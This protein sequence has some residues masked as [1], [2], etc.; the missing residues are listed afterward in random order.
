MNVRFN[1]KDKSNEKTLI[2]LKIRYLRSEKSP[3]VLSTSQTIDPRFWD[4]DKMRAKSSITEKRKSLKFPQHIWLNALLDKFELITLDCL[5]QKLVDDGTLPAYAE[6]REYIRN[7]FATSKNKIT[8]LEYYNQRIKAKEADNT[9]FSRNTI[10]QYTTTYNKIL[11]FEKDTGK[12][13]TWTRMSFSL[14]KDFQQYLYDQGFAQNSIASYWAKLKVILTEAHD[15]ELYPINAHMDRKNKKSLSIGY[16]KADEV[17]LTSSELM[18]LYNHKLNRKSQEIDRDLFLL[19]AFTGGYRFGDLGDLSKGNIVPLNGGTVL[20][21]TTKKTKERVTVPGGWFFTEFLTKYNGE[22]PKIKT[23]QN[24]NISIKKI[25]KAAGLDRAVKLTKNKYGK[26]YTLTRPL[27][28][29]VTQYTA[30]Y[31][32]ATNLF[33]AGMPIEKI[34]RLL[35]HTKIET[36][37]KYIKAK[38]LQTVMSVADNPYFTTKPIKKSK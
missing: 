14:L 38:Q 34:S 13:F 32:F 1:L 24:F 5:R 36:T 37:Q 31:S 19:A 28:E 30:R 3:F 17:Y 33:L 9:N 11:A 22:F 18:K 15:D 4:Y 20:Q 25:A 10:Q 27:H 21:F 8:F 2:Y 12:K 7:Q 23:N 16:H 29:W 6:L 26:N 35:G